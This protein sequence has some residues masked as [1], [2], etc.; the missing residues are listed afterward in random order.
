[1]ARLFTT[2]FSII[3]LAVVVSVIVAVLRSGNKNG[4]AS[5]G[6][7]PSPDANELLRESRQKISRLDYLANQF[8]DEELAQRI[9]RICATASEILRNVTRRPELMGDTRYF[10][11]YYIPVLTKIVQNYAS[12]KGNKASESAISDTRRSV[13]A[14]IAEVEAAFQKQLD[15]MLGDSIIDINAEIAVFKRSL[16]ED[17]LIG[18]DVLGE[19]AGAEDSESASESAGKGAGESSDA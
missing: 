17:G 11:N 12:L 5:P 10:M 13:E 7:A 8:E 2:P 18:D 19:G 4:A 9:K 6:I 15:A 3:L 1:M 14:L 16:R